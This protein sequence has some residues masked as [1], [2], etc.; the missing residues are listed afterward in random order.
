MLIEQNV[1]SAAAQLIEFALGFGPAKPRPVGVGL[2]R[3][4]VTLAPLLKSL[5]IDHVRHLDP[6]SG[7]RNVR[8]NFT[9][10]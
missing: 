9:K 7:R 10:A 3:R 1:G 8:G 6:L 5:E 2:F 4:L